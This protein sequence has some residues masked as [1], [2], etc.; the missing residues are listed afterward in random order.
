MHHL[1][2]TIQLKPEELSA[3]AYA[4]R[5]ILQKL[6]EL[7]A[8]VKLSEISEALQSQGIGLAA[9]RS[10]LASNP[11]RFA[12]SERR[13]IP[14]ARLESE[15]RPFNEIVRLLVDRFGG[16]MPI[17]LV[18]KEVAH[19][20]GEAVD[21][22]EPL[23]RRMVASDPNL[24][25]TAND[26]LVLGSWVF[27]ALDE[28]IERAYGLNHIEE[29]AVEEVEKKLGSFDWHQDGAIRKALDTVKTVHVKALGAAA[30]K[31]LNPQDPRSV[32][33]FDWREFNSELLSQPGYVYGADGVLTPEEEAKKWIS[34]AVKLADRIAPTV[35]IEDAQP[36]EVK[37]SDI[38]KM[39]DKILASDESTTATE[40]LEQFYEITPSVKTFPDDL[41]NV[42]Q[43]LAD[44]G[45]VWWVGGDRF[46][47]PNSAPDFVYGVPDLFQFVNTEYVDAEGELIDVELS[48]EGLSSTLRKLLSHPLATD[49]LD[50]EM[51]PIPKQ[52]QEQIRLVLKPIH[53]ELGTFPMAQLPTGWLDTDPT[54]QE[55]VFN[56][57]TG[58]SL[59]VWAN[60]DARLL[61]NLIDWFYEQP[62]ESGAVFSLSKTHKPNVFE[63]AWLDQTDPVVFITSQRM[64]ELRD[65][66]ARS[67][68]MSTL[69]IL[70]EV[71]AH[72]P[73]GADFLTI[74]WE[75]NVVR[76]VT[77]RLV[78]SL[79]SSYVCFYQ[80][81]GSPVWHYDAKKVD[82]G[83]DKSKRKFVLKR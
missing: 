15:G 46:R 1:A 20:Q 73:K 6:T 21:A 51:L 68:E 29:S 37:S 60:L 80:R 76:R 69:Q 2:K 58:R 17:A 75:V 72:W 13:W 22:V 12:Y 3:R 82:Q 71:M 28:S 56:D 83:F 11:E 16:P 67:E 79:L 77:R 64:E 45:K 25:I 7:H 26:D 27:R 24:L 41:A 36:I 74:L 61:F 65:L 43:A 40:L 57:P 4:D 53:R 8:V 47:K 33:L 38:N 50:E 78:A 5:L 34:A 10:L 59:S 19:T 48:D 44:S 18:A 81:S 62:V 49:V 9:V 14:A 30:W 54:V 70:Q 35:D 63:F 52:Q 66:Q 42:K 31:A 23:I 32:L 55:L 39:I